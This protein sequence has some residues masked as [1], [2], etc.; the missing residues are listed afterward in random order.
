MA[1]L[2][3]LTDGDFQ[4][5]TDMGS[6]D[7]LHEFFFFKGHEHVL[8]LFHIVVFGLFEHLGR[9]AQIQAFLLAA[10]ECPLNDGE[11]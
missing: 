10:V 3:L 4:A 11:R 2:V 1:V 5:I 8:D 6:E 7:I 9:T